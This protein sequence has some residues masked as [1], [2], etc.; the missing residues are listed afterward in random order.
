MQ[1]LERC[2][3]NLIEIIDITLG[4][5]DFFFKIVKYHL[6]ERYSTE[7]QLAKHVCA[8]GRSRLISEPIYT[9]IS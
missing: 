9:L 2:V 5:G 6:S 3:T 7:Y 1:S 8:L 4:V